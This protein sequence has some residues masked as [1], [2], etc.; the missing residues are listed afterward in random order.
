MWRS[1]RFSIIG[2]HATWMGNIGLEKFPV[3]A[4]VGCKKAIR[5]QKLKLILRIS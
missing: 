5:T 4:P 2:S 3:L 1:A